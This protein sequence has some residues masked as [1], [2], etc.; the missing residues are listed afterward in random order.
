MRKSLLFETT[1]PALEGGLYRKVLLLGDGGLPWPPTPNAIHCRFLKIE[2]NTFYKQQWV[3]LKHTTWTGS[4]E[5]FIYTKYAISINT[6]VSWN[7]SLGSWKVYYSLLNV[8]LVD[9][10]KQVLMLQIYVTREAL[11]NT[12][13]IFNEFISKIPSSLD[14]VVFIPYTVSF[15]K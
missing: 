14:I 13:A 11:Y 6:L 12:R 5:T 2:I 10:K 15:S 4:W 9:E 8:T 3:F 1:F 7:S